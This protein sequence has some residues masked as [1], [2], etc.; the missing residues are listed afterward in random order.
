MVES[1]E[2]N[3]FKVESRYLVSNS[4]RS[5][6][7]RVRLDRV[8]RTRPIF[9]TLR[10]EVDHN[11]L[12]SGAKPPAKAPYRMSSPELE[13]LQK[14]ACS[15][16]VSS[17]RQGFYSSTPWNIGSNSSGRLKFPKL[18]LAHLTGIKKK[19]FILFKL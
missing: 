17:V 1:S 4:S 14:Q 10:R 16:V 19:T 6:S 12:V 5:A 18:H 11:K 7:R 15:K 9:W 13:E 3:R 2:S 8:V